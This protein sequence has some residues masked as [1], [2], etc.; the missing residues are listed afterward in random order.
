MIDEIKMWLAAGLMRAP[1]SR[2][3]VLKSAF[4]GR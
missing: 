4:E 2:Q 3:V 1:W